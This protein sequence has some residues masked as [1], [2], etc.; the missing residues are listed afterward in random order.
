MGLA[1]DYFDFNPDHSEALNRAL[2]MQ[3]PVP[4]RV[5]P[6]IQA[7]I[8]LVDLTDQQ[9]AWPFRTGTYVAGEATPV[10]AARTPLTRL[11]NPLNSRKLVRVRQ[12]RLSGQSAAM[13]VYMNVIGP[14][15]ALIP[16]ILDTAA[17]TI[18]PRDGRIPGQ[19]TGAPSASC[20][21]T[22]GT[23]AGAI[24]S[25]DL[26]RLDAT[27]NLSFDPQVT[28]SPGSG[29]WVFGGTVNTLLY[30]TMLWDER[31]CVSSELG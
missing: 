13:A 7:G 14:A 30:T 5:A 25:G 6:L 23:T 16:A 3:G 10:N 20:T 4:S 29:L 27:G 17:R 15:N 8:N 26:V 31:T 9:Y 1:S 18:Q 28:L 11:F 2:N 12:V 22:Q 19:L 24:F 21:Y